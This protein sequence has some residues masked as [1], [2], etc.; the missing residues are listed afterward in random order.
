MSGAG[1]AWAI[2]ALIA[3]AL[4]IA[5]VLLIRAPVRRTFGPQVAYALWALPVLRLAL[6]PLPSGWREGVAAPITP[7]SQV[8]EQVTVFIAPVAADT[9]AASSSPISGATVAALW[10]VGAAA[11]LLWH[12]AR[13]WGFK[14][15][16]L[17]QA[18]ETDRV[19]GVTI[20]ESAAA[21]GPL[22]FGVAR[23]FVAFPRDFA[24]RYDANER[25]L[26]LAH[27]LGHHARGDLI[28]NWVALA[29]LALH[30]FNPLAWVAFH[31]FRADQ[32]MANDARVLAGRGAADRHAYA[33]AIVKAAHGGV[34]SAACHLHTINALKGRLRMLRTDRTTRGRV[35]AGMAGVTA[36]TLAALGVTASGTQA[37]ETIRDAVGVDLAQLDAPPIPPAPV[38]SGERRHRVVIV[39]DGKTRTYEGA[40]ADAYVAANPVQLPPVPPVPP[41]PSPPPVTAAP[42]APPVPP[43][44]PVPPQ[45]YSP[46]GV[47]IAVATVTSQNCDRDASGRI[48]GRNMIVR[49]S[50][51]GNSAMVICTDRIERMARD[52][53]RS[54]EAAA[55][56]AEAA[57]RQAALVSVDAARIRRDAMRSAI[58]GMRATRASMAN[59][60][61]LPEEA[62]REACDDIDAAIADMEREAE[63]GDEA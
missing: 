59:N 1:I 13:Y 6:P 31:T 57:A 7:L 41:M 63:H 28:A 25:D 15:R 47:K 12:L 16:L 27:E 22:A 50:R 19:D 39:Q 45:V 21:A 32:E 23:R 37:A 46:D 42:P 44:P 56:S 14:R 26:A 62:R 5:L 43:V 33:C 49:S 2:E 10:A 34:I 17:A 3:S 60:R 58:E 51:D 55:R 29:V 8:G 48:R 24:A 36:L 30:W 9:A 52:A 35:L 20:V 11:F 40:A 53:A 38:A 54:G 61:A 18:T 4:L